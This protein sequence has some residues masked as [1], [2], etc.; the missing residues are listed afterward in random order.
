[1]KT[2]DVSHR[3]MKQIVQYERKRTALWIRTFIVVVSTLLISGILMFSLIVKDLLEKQAFDLFE[4]FTQD[5]EII[6]EFWHDALTTF[7][8]EVPQELFFVTGIV[9]LVLFIT[10]LITKKRLAIVQKKR[11]QLEKYR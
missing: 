10:I 3:V 9:V 11:H 4:L 8:N 2:V 5:P 7:W 6:A 1:M